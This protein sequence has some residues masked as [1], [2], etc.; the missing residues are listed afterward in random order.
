MQR[1]TRE[2]INLLYGVCQI[3]DEE[4]IWFHVPDVVKTFQVLQKNG[5][6]LLFVPNCS[7]VQDVIKPSRHITVKAN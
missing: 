7:I 5:I 2:S 4:K 1:K 6:T 3:L